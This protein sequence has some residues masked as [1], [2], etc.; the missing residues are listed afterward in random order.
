MERKRI[1][2]SQQGFTLIEIISVLVLIGILAAVAVPKFIDLQTEARNKAAQAAVAEGI[3][4]INMYSAKH[5]L[6]NGTVPADL[7]ALTDLTNPYTNG[8][9]SIAFTEAGGV[10]TVTATG[11]ADTNVAT[12]TASGT[13]ELPST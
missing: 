7:A 9:F 5:I 4:Q 13:T 11:K 3:A 10:I 12:A 1:L 6:V 8:D 2:R